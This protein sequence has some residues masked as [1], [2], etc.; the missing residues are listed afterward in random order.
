MSTQ[1]VWRCSFCDLVDLIGFDNL[2]RRDESY[3]LIHMSSKHG[4]EA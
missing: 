4:I 1:L 3:Y 2:E